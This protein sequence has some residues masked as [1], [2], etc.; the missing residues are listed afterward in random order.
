[1]GAGALS[2]ADDAL[3]GALLTLAPLFLCAGRPFLHLVLALAAS[4]WGLVA[5]NFALAALLPPS[6]PSWVPPL[7]GLLVG[8]A[9][10]FA[11]EKAERFGYFL[12]GGVCGALASNVVL[13]LCLRAEVFQRAELKMFRIVILSVCSI[14]T[15]A[16]LA[17]FNRPCAMLLSSFSGGYML[18]T[19]S[20]HTPHKIFPRAL[21]RPAPSTAA[22]CLC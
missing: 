3:A 2:G 12:L 20:L 6:A 5:T 1:M 15:G 9:L 16:A 19:V 10:S 13:Q 11:V 14:G 17:A 4:V 8:L 18:I 22:R 21:S 7:A